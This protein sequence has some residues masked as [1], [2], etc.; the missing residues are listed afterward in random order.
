[1]RLSRGIAA[2]AAIAATLPLTGGQAQATT[3]TGTASKTV[4]AV[5]S[6]WSVGQVNSLPGGDRTKTAKHWTGSG[7][8][9]VSLPVSVWAGGVEF[10]QGDPP[11]PTGNGL[12][13]RTG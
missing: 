11:D 7:W 6:G 2:G 8:K 12:Y 3:T 1:V 13:L 9:S 10:P 4:R 5:T